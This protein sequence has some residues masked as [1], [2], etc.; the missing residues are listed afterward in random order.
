MNSLEKYFEKFRKNII[1]IDAEFETS[2]GTKKMIYADWIASGRLYAPIEDRMRNL[3]APMVG[4]T[5]SEASETGITMT[6]LY[7]QAQQIIKK[8]VNA[9]DDDILIN[10]GSGMTGAVNKLQRI[11]GLKVPEQAQKYCRSKI[12]K[13]D[14]PIVFITHMEHHSNHTSWLE[15]MADVVVLEPCKGIKTNPDTLRKELKKY[16]NR[17]FKI[18]SFSAG[19]NVT[20]IIPPYYELAEIMHEH[21]GYAFIDFA[22]SFPYIN[23][24]MHPENEMQRLDAIFFS[25]HKALGGPGSSGVLIFNKELYKNKAPDNPGGGTVLWTNR[26]NEYAYV[27]NI[28]TKEDGGTPA[29]LQT[30]RTAFT[31]KLKEKMGCENIIKRE[32][33]LIK[34]AFEEFDKIPSLQILS[35]ENKCRLGVFSFFIKDI[36]HNL[37]VRILNDEFGIQVRGGCSCAGTYGH[38]LLHVTKIESHRITDMINLGNLSEKPGWVRVSIHPTMTNEELYFI[39]KAIKQTV[40]NIN[41]RKKDYYFD[42]E[43]GEFFHNKEARRKQEDFCKW[44]DL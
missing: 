17:K 31:I 23:I 6:F 10:E 26:W 32:H 43:S 13:D 29:F 30:I 39:T 14:Y 37:I 40:E 33:E 25:P 12:D 4:N 7:K 8:H 42:T 41:T 9:F 38:Y 19:S 1:G 44:F 15:T 36:H 34:I 24:D 20:G 22:A 21:G 35:Y 11:I 18:G 2:C 5:H 28:E 27:N 16:K 3:I